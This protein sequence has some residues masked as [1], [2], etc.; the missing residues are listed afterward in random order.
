MTE[1]GDSHKNNNS[2]PIASIRDFSRKLTPK[3]NVPQTDGIEE[4]EKWKQKV[5]NK[6]SELLCL[7][8]FEVDEARYSLVKQQ[9]SNDII[10]EWYYLKT[11]KEY[12]APLVI[13]KPAGKG[14]FVPILCLHGHSENG[15][16]GLIGKTAV[17]SECSQSQ[18]QELLELY[19]DTYAIDLAKRG[20]LTVSFDNRGFN[21][22]GTYEPYIYNAYNW[23]ICEVLWQN[24][25]GRNY[26]GSCVWDAMSV[27]DYVLKRD[28]VNEDKVGCIGFSLGGML[29]LYTS[30]LDQRIS[31]VVISG[32]FDSY[33]NRIA[34][35]PGADCVCNYVP[36]MFEWFDIPDLTAA[37]APKPVLCNNEVYINNNISFKSIDDIKKDINSC[38]EKVKNVY[39]IYK[40]TDKCELFTWQSRCHEFNGKRAYQWLK[41]Q[42]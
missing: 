37:L 2:D 17:K 20:F 23:H 36:G 35:Y 6:L 8:K 14:P 24:A 33:L 4:R 39:Q 5:R 15:K 41:E 13:T 21:E 9:Q 25:L 42:L 29:A 10:Y 18:L 27:L 40:V 28:D 12:W 38:F 19:K 34:E 11:E 22:A 32:Y 1:K 16:E 31:A 7:D 26:I 30:L 3:L